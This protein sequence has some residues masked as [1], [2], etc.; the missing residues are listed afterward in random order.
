MVTVVG[1]NIVIFVVG[2]NVFGVVIIYLFGCVFVVNIVVF[3]FIVSFV[4][5]VWCVFLNILICF[6]VFEFGKVLFV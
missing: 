5:V 1:G 3:V 4:Y 6:I 2:W